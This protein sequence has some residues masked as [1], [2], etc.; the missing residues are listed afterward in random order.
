MTALINVILLVVTGSLLS[1]YIQVEMSDH[2]V[3]LPF[4]KKI[5]ISEK[6]EITRVYLR[7]SI[8]FAATVFE[9]GLW[10]SCHS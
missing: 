6:I 8:L 9:R 10:L 1:L 2:K 5:V 4:S 3:L 7:L